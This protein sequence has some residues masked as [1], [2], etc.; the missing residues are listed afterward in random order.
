MQQVVDHKRVI[1][2]YEFLLHHSARDAARKINSVVGRRCVSHTTASSWFK[3]FEKKKYELKDKARS[4]R[5]LTLDTDRLVEIVES[6]SGQSL[7][8][9]ASK[10]R[11]HH[12]TVAYHLDQLGFSS[13]LGVLVP[14]DLTIYQKNHRVDICTHLMSIKRS[15]YW[16]DNLITGDEKWIVYA[17]RRRG[18]QWVA[19]NRRPLQIPKPKVFEKKVMLSVWWSVRGVEYWKLLPDNTTVTAEVYCAQLDKLKVKIEM[20][21]PSRE[22][23]YFL[24]DNARP[25]T[26]KSTRDKLLDFGWELLPHP[27]YSPDLAPTDYYLFRSLSNHLR[28]KIFDDDIEIKCFLTDFF[29]SKLPE[30]YAKGI[31][32][33]PERWRAVVDNDGTYKID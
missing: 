11:C 7:R 29:S 27:P 32:S 4:G 21:Y 19:P 9:I 8:C 22:E 23:I 30:F 13:K 10:L 6:D 15:T 17:N 14:H 3:K 24:H 2:L 20:S 26:A 31:H 16:L 28:E 5:P 1:L 25:H 18:R 33:L 12:S